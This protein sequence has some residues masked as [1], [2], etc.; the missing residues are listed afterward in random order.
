M[1]LTITSD[2]RA[3]VPRLRAAGSLDST[4]HTQLDEQLAAIRARKPR[5]L[6]LDL[7]DLSYISSAGARVIISAHRAMKAA[8]GSLALTDLQ[9][10]VRMVFELIMA[11]PSLNVF[12]DPAELDRYLG[13]IQNAP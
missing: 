3:G 4:T 13:R 1:A 6:V 10:Q 5:T 11:L 7:K 8:G 9:P 2:E 12:D